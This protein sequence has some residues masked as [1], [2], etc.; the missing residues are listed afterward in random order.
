MPMP[1]LGLVHSVFV[2]KVLQRDG[3]RID[4]GC[5]AYP[6]VLVTLQTQG[7]EDACH[8]IGWNREEKLNHMLPSRK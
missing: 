2:L 4:I 3:T 7:F 6:H 8:G 1:A 5:G